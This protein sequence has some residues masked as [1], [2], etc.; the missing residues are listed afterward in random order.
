[1]RAIRS[2]LLFIFG[3]AAASATA[4]TVPPDLS[5]QLLTGAVNAPVGVRAPHDGSGRRFVFSQAG[6]I[7]IVDAG[8]NL[9]PT[10]FLTVPVTFPGSGGTSG[11][12]GLAFHPDYGHVGMPHNDEFYI[13]YTR[14]SA[15]PKL[16]TTPDQALAR[17]TVS[18][19]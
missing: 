2:I 12:L 3:F 4:Q 6:S 11:L 5:L 17:C 16:G 1:M 19:N 10:P 18:A 9:L 14:P 8:G 15:D 13:T 7:R